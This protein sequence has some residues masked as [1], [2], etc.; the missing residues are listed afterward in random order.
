MFVKISNI[1]KYSNIAIKYSNIE[2]QHKA[3]KEYNKTSIDMYKGYGG[4][5]P[6]RTE[7]RNNRVQSSGLKKPGQN[8]VCNSRHLKLLICFLYGRGKGIPLCRAMAENASFQVIPVIFCR[9]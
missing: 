9:V 2:K 1:E 3:T 8:S 7:F 4:G 6:T 5:E